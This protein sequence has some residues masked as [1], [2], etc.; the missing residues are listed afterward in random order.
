MKLWSSQLWTQLLQFR[1]EAWKIQDFNGIWTR[2]LASPVRRS[3]QLS[4][5]ATD[6]ERWSFVGSNV[7][8]R[9]ESM[10]K[11]YIWN[12]SYMNCG[13]EIKWSYD[14]RSYERNYCNYVEK[15]EKFRTSTGFE[16]VTSR[17]RCDALTMSPCGGCKVCFDSGV[18]KMASY[19][20][21]DCNVRLCAAPCFR[22]FHQ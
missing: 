7:P 2:D 13:Y 19:F 18:R 1:R 6:A 11:W 20:C 8:V 17:Y 15:P 4:Y 16:P 21:P 10:M 12:G 22:T 14:P 9:N 3:T 5:E